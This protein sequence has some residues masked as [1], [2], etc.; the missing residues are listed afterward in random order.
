MP[1]AGAQE[2]VVIAALV[3]QRN[4]VV[5]VD[6][7]V[8]AIWDGAAPQPAHHQVDSCVGRL[9]QGL[10]NLGA[11]GQLIEQDPDGYRLRVDDDEVD[12]D[13][14]EWLVERG[15]AAADAGRVAEAAERL[16]DALDL[17]RG[18]PLQGVPGR[19]AR[20]AAARL[21]E[22]RVA[23]IEEFIGPT[24]PGGLASTPDRTAGGTVSGSGEGAK[25]SEG[26]L[27]PR[28][29]E[30]AQLITQGLTNAEIGDHLVISKRTVESHVVH[31]KH[32]LGL[33]RRTQVAVWAMGQ[34]KEPGPAV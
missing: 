2:Q 8:T 17:W 27:S 22:R 12:L 5:P 7:L 15:R 4:Q 18:A 32:K 1:L 6:A 14:F 28:E 9:R 19:W 30:I 31:I 11:P 26:P 20:A 16:S 29:L 21:A 23:V 34:A 33:A 24:A 13:V 3:L 10:E 25:G